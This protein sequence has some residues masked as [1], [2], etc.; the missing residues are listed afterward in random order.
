MYKKNIAVV[1]VLIFV[2]GLFFQYDRTDGFVR[3][4]T[5]KNQAVAAFG[6]GK[7]VHSDKENLPRETFLVVYDSGDLQSLFLRKSIENM[8]NE[9]KKSAVSVAAKDEI[10]WSRPY[11]GIVIACSEFNQIK[12]FARIWQYLADGG[13]VAFMMSLPDT[14][15]SGELGVQTLGAFKT[16]AGVKMRSNFLFGADGF[17]TDTV[18]Y[19]TYA[20]E[21]ALNDKAKLHM[22][23]YEGLPLLWET[24]VGRGKAIVYNGTRI[25]EKINRGLMAGML[26]QLKQSYIYP[27]IGMKVIFIDDFPAPEPEGNFEKIYNEFHLSTAQFMR[28]IWWPDMLAFAQKY[29]IKYTGLIIESYNNRVEGPFKPDAGRKAKDNLIIYG[30]ELLRQGGE[31][32]VHG[33]NHQ[34]LAPQ[35]YAPEDLGYMA[36]PSQAAMIEA[37]T[38]LKAYIAD[39]YPDYEIR[40]YVPPSNVLSPMGKAA[41]QKAFPNLKI[42]ASLYN[43]APED[44]GYYQDFR[45]NE[46]GTYELPRVSSG[47]IPSAAMTWENINVLNDKGVFSHFVHPD[48]L[49]YE[50]SEDLT[51]RQM[52]K[53]FEKMLENLQKNYGWL[54]ACTASQGA[55]YM[56]QYISFEYRVVEAADSLTVYSWGLRAEAY[57]IFKTER[58]VGSAAGCQ[59]TEIDDGVY[60]VKIYDEKATIALKGGG[61]S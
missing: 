49:F 60:L 14:N 10:D 59:L 33:Y 52:H 12:A 22:T 38:E 45:K 28:Q 27:I 61:A 36:W 44:R 21:V 53:G 18:S 26:S 6:E 13:N 54:R 1:F 41:V 40:T 57:F 39:V 11:S 32:G 50:E 56:D 34:S 16:S 46:D 20:R 17:S 5:H 35:G 29:D 23:S 43:G 9:Q 7:N 15:V 24:A 37:L 47:F 42:F 58:E 31:L 30:R 4:I 55:E 51:W 3:L 19:S 8:L 25:A 2:L 48:E